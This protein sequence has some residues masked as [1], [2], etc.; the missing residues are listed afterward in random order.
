MADDALSASQPTEAGWGGPRQRQWATNGKRA[1][2]HVEPKAYEVVTLL[3]RLCTRTIKDMNAHI[4]A[5]GLEALVGKP[6][7]DIATLPHRVTPAPAGTPPLKRTMTTEGVQ[8]I[9]KRI[10]FLSGGDNDGR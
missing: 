1:V 3:A 2:V 4:Y 9:A 6:I 10:E 7:R 5:A 8:L